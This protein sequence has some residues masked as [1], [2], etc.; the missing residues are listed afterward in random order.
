[1]LTWHGGPGAL[2]IRP[3]ASTPRSQRQV[4]SAS[5]AAMRMQEPPRAHDQAQP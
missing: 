2:A 5:T 1:M 4:D 3:Y